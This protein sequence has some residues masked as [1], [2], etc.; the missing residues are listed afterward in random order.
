MLLLAIAFSGDAGGDSFALIF[1][2][3]FVFLSAA[4][5]ILAL[6]V[7]SAETNRTGFGM[8]C[9]AVVLYSAGA[10]ILVGALERSQQASSNE[11]TLNA[12]NA[13]KQVFQI[14]SCAIRATVQSGEPPRDLTSFPVFADCTR[15]HISDAFPTPGYK[16]EL[17]TSGSKFRLD[18][19]PQSS[20]KEAFAVDNSGLVTETRGTGDS[21]AVLTHGPMIITA[22]Q[23]CLEESKKNNGVY[24]VNLVSMGPGGKNCIPMDGRNQ[25][26]TTLESNTFEYQNMYSVTY[27]PIAMS[28]RAPHAYR[29]S[30]T[31][32]RYGNYC[33][34][35]L[36]LDETGIVHGTGEDR[37]ARS[38]D[39]PS[40]ACELSQFDRCEVAELN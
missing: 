24:P 7:R 11:A 15:S 29:L 39:P 35:S 2:L 32:L 21:F 19:H 23:R 28:G 13:R 40:P 18:L 36:L 9:L 34:R 1:F 27:T 3:A 16:L 20:G 5:A 26:P 22:L 6:R 33:L 12:L 14:A 4:I 8:G 17:K 37:P 10:M 38:D 30:A 25:Y 31:C